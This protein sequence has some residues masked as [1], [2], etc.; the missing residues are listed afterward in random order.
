MA[1]VAC[2][3][4]CGQQ[5]R[6]PGRFCTGCREVIADLVLERVRYR[7]DGVELTVNVLHRAMYQEMA[8][9]SQL[10]LKGTA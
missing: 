5:V 8:A 1:K 2:A 3:G 4:A 7:M 6:Q 9:W 10:R